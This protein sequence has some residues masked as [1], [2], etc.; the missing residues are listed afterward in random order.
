M[1]ITPL[2]FFLVLADAAFAKTN[3]HVAPDFSRPQTHLKIADHFADEH[4][5]YRA[6][7]EYKKVVFLF[8]HYE[9]IDWVHFQIGRMYYEGGRYP[10]AKHELLPLTESKD[11]NLKFFA[12]NYIALS[13]YENAEFANA[14]R[15]FEEL[16]TTS[17]GAPYALDYTIYT[18]MAAAGKRDFKSAYDRVT[19]AKKI[20]QEKTGDSG[21]LPQ[22]KTFFDS[23]LPLVDKARDLSPKSPYWAI[24]FLCVVSRRRAFFSARVGYRLCQSQPRRRCGVS[25]L[26]RFYARK[27]G[28]STDLY[29]VCHRCVYRANLF[30]L[31]HRT[32]VQ[33]RTRRYGVS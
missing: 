18:G 6:I 16:K 3:A 25:R 8:P 31:P 29:D 10:Q 22:Y 26:R 27:Y 14:E 32:Q 13:Y 33:R 4:D 23:A 24:F 5:Y 19:N 17:A 15:L 11:D 9:K 2:L 28:T 12:H 7:T 21:N 20:W 30:K 1:R